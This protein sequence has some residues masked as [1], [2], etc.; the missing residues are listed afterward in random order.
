[1]VIKIGDRSFGTRRYSRRLLLLTLV[2]LNSAATLD[3]YYFKRWC[4]SIVASTFCDAPGAYLP[5]ASAQLIIIV[6]TQF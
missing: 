2:L 5:R 4:Y 6:I 1:M 3:G